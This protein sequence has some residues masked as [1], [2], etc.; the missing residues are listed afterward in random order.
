MHLLLRIE[1][2]L[3]ATNTPPTRLGG[4]GARPA[5]RFRSALSAQPRVETERRSTPGSTRAT[6][7]ECPGEQPC[8]RALATSSASTL[9]TLLENPVDRSQ[10]AT[11]PASPSPAPATP[12][13]AT[14]E[15]RRSRRRRRFPRGMAE[16]DLPSR[17]NRRRH[18][19]HT[20]DA[21][22]A[23]PMPASTWRR[24]RSRMR[25]REGGSPG[26]SPAKAGSS[27]QRKRAG[28]GLQSPAEV[29]LSACLA[30]V[31]GPGTALPRPRSETL[32]ISAPTK[33]RVDRL[34]SS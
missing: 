11:G 21:A 30:A 28:P 26:C 17:P 24:S 22:T 4:G 14:L 18:R 29:F 20:E 5:L 34:R 10:A 31:E 15:V 8:S 19:P 16:L 1:R 27:P 33:P 3:R 32:E 13:A 7:R 9:S 6:P 12:Y 23:A 2:Y 25:D